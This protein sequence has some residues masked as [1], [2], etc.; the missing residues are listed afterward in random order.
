MR[1][2]ALYGTAVVILATV[3]HFLHGVSHAGQHLMSLPAWQGVYVVVVTLLAPVV[4]ALLLWSRF[5]R[6]GAWLLLAS[7]A[8]S[9]AFGLAFHFVVPGADNVF[10]LESRAWRVPFQ[11]TAALLLLVHG[12]GCV[13]GAW[14]IKR[15]MRSPGEAAGR[16]GSSEAGIEQR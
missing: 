12:I 15:L 4:A 3:A 2:V 7:M 10:T 8:G 6:V 14:A 16:A 11:V 1:K 9:F 5:R 13:V